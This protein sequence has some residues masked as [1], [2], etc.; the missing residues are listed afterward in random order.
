MPLLKDG[1][2]LDIDS[3]SS[4]AR[5]ENYTPIIDKYISNVRCS[6]MTDIGVIKRVSKELA[7]NLLKY[8]LN[9]NDLFK[10]FILS[11]M[12]ASLSVESFPNV[13][14][15][16]VQC[17]G[18]VPFGSLCKVILA[19]TS[20]L[21]IIPSIKENEA[22]HLDYLDKLNEDKEDVLNRAKESLNVHSK[23]RLDLD[24]NKIFPGFSVLVKSSLV[25]ISNNS[26]VLLGSVSIIGI[27]GL[28]YKNPQLFVDIKQTLSSV[29]FQNFLPQ[30]SE[31]PISENT[32]MEVL[33]NRDRQS[34]QIHP[35]RRIDKA[36]L[37]FRVFA[38]KIFGDPDR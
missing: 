7:D 16:V 13:F 1:S 9:T 24:N 29:P 5:E 34:G 20:Q 35:V 37:L 30:S 36:Y 28:F 26:R 14:L 31:S 3:F 17:Y 2:Q 21:D 11:N 8:M 32:S 25:F 23:S 38:I 19:E 10:T 15:Y 33:Y 12:T 18:D 4:F 27:A 6:D 22:F